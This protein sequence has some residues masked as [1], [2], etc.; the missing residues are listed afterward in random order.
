MRVKEATD[1]IR[2]FPRFLLVADDPET[3]HVEVI[4]PGHPQDPQAL[5]NTLISI[6]AGIKLEE[7]SAEAEHREV[8]AEKI[9]AAKVEAEFAPGD[10][11][12]VAV[13][14]E[15]RSLVGKE[16]RVVDFA[17]DQPDPKD[18]SYVLDIDGQEE[19]VEL[20]SSDLMRA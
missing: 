10:R 18:L 1:L 17:G 19:A 4:S 2:R 13:W 6:A 8:S 3:E 20:S 15:E 11:V 14:C 9:E 5:A 12:K 16:A 7:R